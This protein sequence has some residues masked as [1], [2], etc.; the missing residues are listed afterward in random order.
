MCSLSSQ[1]LHEAPRASLQSRQ[2]AMIYHCL[3]R[4]LPL[5]NQTKA[6]NSW[7]LSSR[8]FSFLLPPPHLGRGMAKE[9]HPG[10]LPFNWI[11]DGEKEQ[12]CRQA[13]G[14]RDRGKP[15]QHPLATVEQEH[16]KLGPGQECLSQCQRNQGKHS[17]VPCV[18]QEPVAGPRNM[19][20]GDSSFE[21]IVELQWMTAGTI[22]PQNQRTHPVLAKAGQVPASTNAPSQWTSKHCANALAQREKP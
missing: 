2:L 16:S 14:P 7:L 8:D 17:Q 21:A 6:V 20:S 3:R 4:K 5:Q 9:V 15:Q 18:P 1:F 19:Q 22:L 12:K 13:Q 11:R 10:C